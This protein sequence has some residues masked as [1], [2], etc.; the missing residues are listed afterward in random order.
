M[1]TR[2]EANRSIL[3]KIANEVENN[4]EQRFHQILQNM[5]IVKL[6]GNVVV[7][8]FYEESVDTL[9]RL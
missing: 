6:N 4:P 7:D 5:G 9:D 1:M 8:Q 2:L 3:E